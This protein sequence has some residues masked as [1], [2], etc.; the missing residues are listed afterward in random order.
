[1]VTPC[2]V[3][4]Q[5]NWPVTAV[6]VEHA[7]LL[8][9]NKSVRRTLVHVFGYADR[10]GYGHIVIERPSARTNGGAPIVI[11]PQNGRISRLDDY[12]GGD[13]IDVKGVRV[14][15]IDDKDIVTDHAHE[16]IKPKKAAR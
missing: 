4:H 7:V 8:S 2:S 6:R 15:R 12:L 13:I 1:V 10:R 16:A 3:C 5:T 14:F 11:D 9:S